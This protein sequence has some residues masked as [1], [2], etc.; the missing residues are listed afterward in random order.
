M[1][2]LVSFLLVC[3]FLVLIFAACGTQQQT[4][5]QQTTAQQTTAQQ[6]TTVAE[7]VTLTITDYVDQEWLK[8]FWDNF[9]KKFEEKYPNYD[10]QV[11]GIATAQSVEEF[12]KVKIAADEF[13]D[14]AKVWQP[15]L[16]ISSGLIQETPQEFQNML[17]DPTS[18][19]YNGKIYTMPVNIGFLGLAYNKDIFQKAGVDKAP[20]TWSEFM[21]ACQKIKKIGVAPIGA[22]KDGWF[23]SSYWN[24]MWS[25]VTYGPEPNWSKLRSEGKVKFNNPVTRRSLE[26]FKETVQYWQEGAMSTNYDQLLAL[27]SN[28]EVAMFSA[29]MY[30]ATAMEQGTLKINFNLGYMTMPQDKAEDRRVNYYAD[31]AWVI[32]SKAEGAKLQACK[33]FLNL[34]FSPGEYEESLNVA[35]SMPT[36]KGFESYSPKGANQTTEVFLKEF[37]S[38]GN[39]LGIVPHG[40]ATQGDNMWPSGCREMTEKISQEIAIGNTKYDELMDMFDKQWDIGMAQLK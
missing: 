39:L 6:T 28:Q 13:P 23:L 7:K 22:T 38:T 2:R 18:F 16:M 31:S 11:E 33:D 9:S 15:A 40:H 36:V 21:A 4:T 26:R 25:P 5:A 14:V 30:N 32:N 3:T 8:N 24:Y 19:M 12:Y 27:F 34:Y 10:L 1:K 17:I 29:G 20:E 37:S 35:K